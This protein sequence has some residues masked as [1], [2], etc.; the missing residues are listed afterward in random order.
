MNESKLSEVIKEFLFTAND[1]TSQLHAKT[2][3][4]IKMLNSYDDKTNDILVKLKSNHANVSDIRSSMEK[5]DIIDKLKKYMHRKNIYKLFELSLSLNELSAT[6]VDDLE[7]VP[8]IVERI[9][10]DSPLIPSNSAMKGLLISTVIKIKMKQLLYFQDKFE[11]HLQNESNDSD[12]IVDTDSWVEFLST[13]KVWLMAYCCVTLLPVVLTESKSL[14]SER[15]IESLDE[16]LT[17]LW[18]RFHF[19]LSASREKALRQFNSYSDVVSQLSSSAFMNH[20]SWTFSYARNFIDLILGLCT[21]IAISDKLPFLD[22]VKFSDI[23]KEYVVGKAIRFMRAHLA[24]IISTLR[25][26]SDDNCLIIVEET[27]SVDHY[28]SSILTQLSQQLPTVYVSH[29]INDAKE[30]YFKWLYV[31][32]SRFTALMTSF[33]QNANDIY[34]FE[35]GSQNSEKCHRCYKGVYNCMKLF[36]L[37]T[38]RY[39][40]IIITLLFHIFFICFYIPS[41]VLCLYMFSHCSTSLQYLKICCRN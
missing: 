9:I 35:F 4:Y 39:Q 18:G 34:S 24:D 20:I 15:H 17:P 2:K 41:F 23:A 30:F 26:I 16:A 13:S 22:T 25:P 32:C 14:V 7:K 19:H 6:C 40:V 37:A 12:N 27:L 1:N 11:T 21:E 10:K 38:Q 31:E 8:D 28:F 5:L 29:V 36:I 33:L 3:D